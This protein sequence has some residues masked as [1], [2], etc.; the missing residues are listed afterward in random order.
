MSEEERKYKIFKIFFHNNGDKETIKELQKDFTKNRYLIPSNY[1]AMKEGI[2][3]N[4]SACTIRDNRRHYTEIMEKYTELLNKM[5]RLASELN[6]ENSLE[7]SIL[8]S[9]LL[10]NGYLSKNKDY[11][12][13]SKDKNYITGLFFTDIMDGRGVCLNN[14]EMLKDFLEVAGYTSSIIQNYYNNNAK[15][16]YR[17]KIKTR[18]IEIEEKENILKKYLKKDANHVF[19][20]IEENDKL[21]IFDPTNLLLHKLINK[22]KSSLINGKG[23]FRLYPYQSHM[24]CANI[25]EVEL[26]DKLL[27]SSDYSSP[28]IKEDLISTAEINI[29]IIKNSISLLEDF[30]KEVYPYIIGIS[31]EKSK[32]L[33]REK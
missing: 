25:K 26:L 27:T 20:L 28:F 32:I 12:F 7:L 17:I 10:W 31:E 29:E 21:Y 11:V 15:I 16:N 33:R 22:Y 23:E 18:N 1:Y 8:Y 19:N 24:N 14:S 9:Y 2:L 4:I 13:S 30:F 6:M 5:A 3:A